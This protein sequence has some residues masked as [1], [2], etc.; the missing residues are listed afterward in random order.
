MAAE[1]VAKRRRLSPPGDNVPGFANWDLEH[2]YE[3]KRRKGK[4]DKPER[5]LVKKGDDWKEDERL[6]EVARLEAE[7]ANDDESMASD[8]DEKDLSLIHI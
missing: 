2:S 4:K 5:L 8:E 6:K 7:G 3:Q 1:P